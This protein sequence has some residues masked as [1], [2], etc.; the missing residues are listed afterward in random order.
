MNSI[1][2]RSRTILEQEYATVA[3]AWH[4]VS[5]RHFK[6]MQIQEEIERLKKQIR[7]DN[8]IIRRL[9]RGYL[10]E[11][12]DS[13]N[14]LGTIREA[15]DHITKILKSIVLMMEI[16]AGTISKENLAQIIDPFIQFLENILK[17]LTT[18][19][20][21]KVPILGDIIEILRVLSELGRLKQLIP[22]DAR[23]KFEWDMMFGGF[24]DIFTIPEE[25]IAYYERILE[26]ARAF[27]AQLPLY[28]LIIIAT[29][30][31]VIINLLKKICDTLHI[32]F[33]F[34]FEAILDVG[35]E[36]D[37]DFD[38]FK[39]IEMEPPKNM[40]EA[41]L[42]LIPMILRGGIPIL[43]MIKDAIMLKLQELFG[44]Y[45]YCTISGTSADQY[46]SAATFDAMS[47]DLQIDVLTLS[48]DY[49]EAED[50]EDILGREL[51]RLEKRQDR[52]MQNF[53]DNQY[54][55]DQYEFLKNHYQ[56]IYDNLNN[57]NGGPT[58]LNA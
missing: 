3:E 46:L 31:M 42:M 18:G 8:D 10:F 44:L 9:N 49:L 51:K 33:D 5:E 28:I 13:F 40:L 55:A 29:I 24:Y 38:M 25:W 58:T 35:W 26:L 19:V 50:R 21:I 53:Y 7:S 20:K 56:N 15:K 47:C 11:I 12:E 14:I 57:V 52:E 6:M 32:D 34:S 27:A 43:L 17:I 45:Y 2:D 37:V 54:K 22:D 23:E 30:L 1:F 41:L 4:T 48:N 39:W 16:M 36:L